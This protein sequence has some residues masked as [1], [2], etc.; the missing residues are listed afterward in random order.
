MNSKSVESSQKFPPGRKRRVLRGLPQLHLHNAIT[1]NA[2]CLLLCAVAYSM[3]MQGFRSIHE[4]TAMASLRCKVKKDAKCRQK[5]PRDG[6]ASTAALIYFCFIMIVGF[7]SALCASSNNKAEQQVCGGP[8]RLRL[9]LY[10][11]NSIRKRMVWG[12]QCC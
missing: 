3:L 11:P 1:R 4:S 7:P 12:T 5:E 9:L 10:Q 8:H 6:H 2:E